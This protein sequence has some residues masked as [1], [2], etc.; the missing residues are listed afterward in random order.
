MPHD[1]VLNPSG[2]ARA[3]ERL[4]Q[5]MPG[6]TGYKTR[7]RLRDEDRAVREAVVRTLGLT[8]GR[9]ERA[10]ASVIR[11][12]P[13]TDVESADRLLRLVS[14]QRDRIRFAPVG[15][16]SLFARKQIQ[17]RELEAVLGLD[18]QLWAALEELDRQAGVWDESSRRGETAWP[19]AA[20]HN[21]AAEI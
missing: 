19:S 2:L 6:Y 12:L 20:L 17:E 3:A 21:A 1:P 7:E 18:V 11:S 15:Y 16:A 14:R 13:A 8:L 4:A 5:L 9:L 10:L